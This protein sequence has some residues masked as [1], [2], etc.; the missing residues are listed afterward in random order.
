MKNNLMWMG[1]GIMVGCFYNTYKK[2][3]NKMICGMKNKVTNNMSK[4]VNNM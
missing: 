1:A 3:I 4:M 2:D